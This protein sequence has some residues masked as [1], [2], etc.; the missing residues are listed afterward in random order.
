MSPTFLFVL[1]VTSFIFPTTIFSFKI[2]IS[3]HADKTAQCF[4]IRTYQSGARQF[5]Y[6]IAQ[7]VKTRQ[8]SIRSLRGV[9]TSNVNK[10]IIDVASCACAKTSSAKVNELKQ[11]VLLDSVMKSRSQRKLGRIL[12]NNVDA[13]IDYKKNLDAWNRMF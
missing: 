4:P 6:G 12:A 2:Q 13:C 5:F 1:T 10:L 9:S 11:L 7:S 3:N 8:N